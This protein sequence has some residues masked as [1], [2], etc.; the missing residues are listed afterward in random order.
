MTTPQPQAAG[1]ARRIGALLYDALL[2]LALLFVAFIP[3][4]IITEASGTSTLASAITTLYLLTICFLFYGW[5]W[6]HGGQ[7][8]GM[9]SWKLKIEQLDGSTVN[10][11][12]AIK[13]YLLAL[14]TLGLGILWIPFDRDHLAWHDRL[15]GTRIIHRANDS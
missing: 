11:P 13:R 5:F 7:T 14:F 8:L 15:S 1:V 3:V 9:R 4:T 10:W 12:L 6:T 2:L